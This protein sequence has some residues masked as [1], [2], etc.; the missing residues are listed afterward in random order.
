MDGQCRTNDGIA[1]PQLELR[2][3]KTNGVWGI[4]GAV[5]RKIP[6]IK[7]QGARKPPVERKQGGTSYNPLIKQNIQIQIDMFN[8]NLIG[9]GMRESVLHF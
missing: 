8:A 5:Y 9:F 6:G 7:N 4:L 3:A 2:L 1:L